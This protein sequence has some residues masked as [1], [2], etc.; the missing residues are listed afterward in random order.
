MRNRPLFRVDLLWTGALSQVPSADHKRR[1]SFSEALGTCVSLAGL[2]VSQ[3]GGLKASG[4]LWTKP[5]Y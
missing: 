2:R 1:P 4:R 5:A 3:A